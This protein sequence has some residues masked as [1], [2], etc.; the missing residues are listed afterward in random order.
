MRKSYKDLKDLA[1]HESSKTIQE[2]VQKYDKVVYGDVFQTEWK[3][4]G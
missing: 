1:R 3:P 2:F 4:I